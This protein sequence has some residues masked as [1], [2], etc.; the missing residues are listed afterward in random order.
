MTPG[1][2]S[3]TGYVIRLIPPPGWAD[4]DYDRALAAL[5]FHAVTDALC[6]VIA[7]RLEKAGLR[8]GPGGCRFDVHLEGD[9]FGRLAG[10]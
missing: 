8:F 10:R 1:P 3:I 9:E 5:D 7:K 2:L 6:D 4:A